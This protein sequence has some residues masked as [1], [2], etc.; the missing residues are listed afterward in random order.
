MI[1]VPLGVLAFIA[2]C[3]ATVIMLRRSDPLPGDRDG[4]GAD[5]LTFARPVWLSPALASA[6]LVMALIYVPRPQT[7]LA[8]PPPQWEFSS[9]LHAEPAPLRPDEVE[10]LTREGAGSA[11]RWRFDWRG[12][13]GSMI[14]ITSD[15][16]RAQHR[17]ERC[18]EVYGLSLEQSSTYLVRADFPLRF[19]SLGD[20][21]GHGVL[22]ATYWFQSAGRTTDDYGARMWADLAPRRERWVLVTVLFDRWHAPQEADLQMFF[23]VLHDAVQRHLEGKETSWASK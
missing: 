23:G 17:P 12:I 11:D 8:Q 15:T 7:G 18:F 20:R 16:W 4:V 3:A 6:V 5:T 14:L 13:T 1:H 19:V 2:V 21:R 22:S 10:W 9:E